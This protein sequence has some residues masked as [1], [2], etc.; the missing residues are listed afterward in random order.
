MTA[1][2]IQ[3]TGYRSDL[4]IGG[5]LLFTLY[6]T[7]LYNYLL[8][9]TIAEIFTVVVACGIFVIA[10]NARRTID[11]NYF[12]FVG[13][14]YLFVGS[15]DL[16]HA[17][18]YK[19]M[20]VFQGFTANEGVQLWVIARYLQS[21]TLLLAPLFIKRRIGHGRLVAGYAAV[22]TL[23]LLSV[24]AWGNFPDCFVEGRGLTTF[25]IVSEYLI[26]SMFAASLIPMFARREAF[27]REMMRRLTASIVFL[28]LSELAF[29]RYSDPYDISNMVGHLLK[30][31]AFYLVYKALIE[32]CLTRPYDLLFRNLKESEKRYRHLYKVRKHAEEALRESEERFRSIFTST[33]AGMVIVS[34][35]RKIQ[36]VNPAFCRFTGYSETELLEL[37]IDDITHPEDRESVSDDFGE[38]FEGR[39]MSNHY[40]KRYLRKDGEVVW[41]HASVACVLDNG[42]QPLYCIKL[43]QDITDHKRLEEKLQ[44]TNNDLDA[45]VHTVS[46]DLRS[47]LTPIIGY[48]E[49]LM[50]TRK[51]KLDEETLGML[52]KIGA[53][54]ERMLHMLE[55]LLALARVGYLE[56]PDKPVDCNKVVKEC[57]AEMM[58]SISDFGVMVKTGS[59]PGTRIPQTLLTEVFDNLIGNAVHY[60]GRNGG[61]I[62]V[63]G[64]RKADLVKYYVRDHGPGIPES[65]RS[66]V[67]DLFFRGSTGEGIRG[68]G[69]GL[70][71]V[72]KIARLYGGRAWVEETPGGGST[73]LVEVVDA[74]GG[75]AEG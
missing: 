59:L 25:K 51:D 21:A 68:T 35:E 54:G 36:Q 60:A 74:E 45:F 49:L 69:V 13:I 20:G 48:V 3:T 53:Q 31:G 43:V 72:Q 6:L 56:R 9:H 5:T 11:N 65:E 67:F 15:V 47:P 30:V 39:C 18:A 73:F 46:H 4:I 1:G 29:T 62:E 12:I 70:A 19:N 32:A 52:A 75:Q 26:A 2:N 38:I 42:M 40:E 17:L 8:F 34:R 33:A 64:E 28:V 61:T 27:D 63:G 23:L 58:T 50:E 14:G 37:S 71:T 41:G 10:W 44:E 7:S 24:F 55:D 66:R 57:I 16:L 22:C